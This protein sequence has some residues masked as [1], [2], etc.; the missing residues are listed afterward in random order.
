[1][2]QLK[3]CVLHK[4]KGVKTMATVKIGQTHNDLK[5]QN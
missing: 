5:I 2:K 3:V 4:N 1:M